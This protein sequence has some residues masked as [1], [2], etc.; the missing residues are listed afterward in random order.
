[1]ANLIRGQVPF[2]VAGREYFVQYGTRELAEA[3]GALGFHRPPPQPDVLEEV[4]VP[5]VDGQGRPRV[6]DQLRPVFRRQRVLVDAAERQRRMI[7]SFEAC[8]MNPDPEASIEFLR[9][10]LGPWQRSEGVRLSMEQV[11]DIAQGLGLTRLRLLH[12]KAISL[13]AYLTGEEAE[14]DAGRGKDG[15]AASASST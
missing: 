5:D 12:M 11:H 8:L 10:G 9:V 15:S 1:M 13:G 2:K 4:D 3:Q 14:E 7:A 6:D